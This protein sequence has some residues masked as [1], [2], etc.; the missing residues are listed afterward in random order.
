M[1]AILNI[2][3]LF[4][5]VFNQA[6]QSTWSRVLNQAETPAATPTPTL[7][8]APTETPQPAT[9]TGTPT[10]TP[11]VDSPT[12]TETPSVESPT[13]TETAFPDTATP[14]GTP[15]LPPT[16]TDVPLPSETPT[17]VP[18][19]TP[20]PDGTP[21]GTATLELGFTPAGRRLIL[22]WK[23]T[24][25][26]FRKDTVTLE[27][28]LPT[29]VIP[30]N[31][32]E[33]IFDPA[34]GILEV[35][36]KKPNGNVLLESGS[37]ESGATISASLFRDGGLAAN[38]VL[39]L[40]AVEK[41]AMDERGGEFTALNGRV[42]V[43]F[44]Q[45][46]LAGSATITVGR[47]DKRSA[48]DFSLSGNEFEIEAFADVND[49]ELHTFGDR[50]TI[51]IEYD[52]SSISGYE[53][54]LKLHWYN[55][56]KDKWFV[57]PSQ[58]DTEANILRGYTD[59][60]STFDYGVDSLQ[61]AH[62]PTLDTFQ[63]AEFTGAASYS[64]PIKVP[65]GPAGLQPSLALSYNSQVIDQ[66]SF[67]T[68]ASWVGMGWSLDTP[69]IERNNRG[70]D[71]E[72]VD[73]SF[74]LTLNGVGGLL[75]KGT[76]GYYHTR[77]ESF[78]RIE[79][80][81]TAN[82]WTAYDK[83]GTKYTFNHKSKFGKAEMTWRW[84]LTQI[85]DIHGN[86]I[87]Y[88]YATETKTITYYVEISEGVD[89][90]RHYTAT[91]AVYPNQITYAKNKY[92]I[93]F[94][95]D[96]NRG[97]YD[98]TWD[99][100]YDDT[101]HMR[102]RLTAIV[103]EHD[104]DGDGV[105]TQIRKYTFGYETDPAK[106]I[107]PQ[108][109][110]DGG[111]GGG[112]NLTLTSVKEY[113][114]AGPALPATTFEYD[115]MHL[116]RANNGYGGAVEFVY[117]TTPWHAEDAPTYSTVDQRF[118]DNY[119]YSGTRDFY[120]DPYWVV[121]NSNDTGLFEC[122][123]GHLNFAREIKN[124]RLKNNLTNDPT[125]LKPGSFYRL[126][127]K[128]SSLQVGGAWLKLGYYDGYNKTYDAQ[129]TLKIT[130]KDFEYTF[131]L[132]PDAKTLVPYLD[133]DGARMTQFTFEVLPTF[134][135]VT[136]K[137]IYSGAGSDPIIYE[138]AYANPAMNSPKSGGIGISADAATFNPFTQPYSEFRGHDSVTVTHPDGHIVT[139]EYHQA[140]RIQGQPSKVTVKTANANGKF[141]TQS[142]MYYS[143]ENIP[144][145]TDT[146]ALP[147]IKPYKDPTGGFMTATGL[148][149]Y[150]RYTTE[151]I[152]KMYT[153]TGAW[154]VWNA[155]RT[156]FDTYDAYG[157]LRLSSE[158]SGDSTS[159]PTN[160]Q[161]YRTTET[162]YFPNTNG[163]YLAGFP[164]SVKVSDDT[165]AILSRVLYVYDGQNA[166]SAPPQTGLLTSV[167]TLVKF[168]GGAGQYSFVDYGYDAYGNQDSVTTYDTLSTYNVTPT[169]GARTS[170]TVFDPNFHV[171]PIKMT[172]PI[173]HETLLEY[174]FTLGVPTREIPP[175]SSYRATSQDG[176]T[177]PNNNQQDTEAEYD[178]FGRVTK[179]I[180]PGDNADYPTLA[181]I[182]HDTNPFW[183]EIRQ[184]V[185]G[186][187]YYALRRYYDGMGRQ[188]KVQT[189]HIGPNG[190]FVQFN[191]V[192]YEY[193]YDAQNDDQYTT[194]QSVPYYETQAIDNTT[195]NQTYTAF[196]ALGRPLTVTAP[197]GTGASYAY[198]GLKT[199]VTDASG[200]A[201]ISSTDAWGNT[202][203]VDPADGP[204]VGYQYDTLSR[205]TQAV[206]G[207]EA[208]VSSCLGNST[209]CSSEVT[210]TTLT[211]DLAG[212]KLS[213]SDPDMGNWAYAYD[214]LGNLT[215]QKD[216]RGQRICLYY[217]DLNRLVGKHY[218]SDNNC[219]AQS[220]FTNH[221]LVYDV[222]FE[223]DSGDNGLGFRTGMS[224]A[225]GSTGWTYDERGRVE[226][227]TKSLEYANGSIVT[228]Q[229]F[230]T[231]WAYNSADL[232]ISMKYPDGED[233]RFDYT[234]QMMLDRVYRFNSS[235]IY[236]NDTTYDTA[237]RMTQRV[238][239]NDVL[240]QDYT[241]YAWDEKAAVDTA[242]VG[243]GGRLKSMTVGTLQ[244][245]DYL[246]DAVGNI[247][248][249]T[250]N[251]ASETNLYAYDSLNR[252]TQW[253][254]NGVNET[255]SY[256][257]NTGNLD[258]KADVDLNYNDASHAHAV[259]H[260][261]STQKYWYD[262]NGNQTK[263]VIG[264]D[265]FTL[266]YDAENRLVEV[267]KNSTTI[268]EFTFDGD[269]KRV[270]SVVDGETILFVGAHYEVKNPQS[271]GEVTKYYFAGASRIA[272]RKYTI[273]VS[274]S[275]EYMIGDHLG[276]TSMTTDATGVKISE[277]RY[278]AWGETRYTWTDAPA[279]PSPAYA[280]T[281]YQYTGQFSYEAEF[282]L[283]FYNARWYDSQLGRFAQAD[284]DVPGGVQ[285]L[286]RYV[287][288]N[289][290]PAMFIDLTGHAPRACVYGWCFESL[291]NGF[292]A[293]LTINSASISANL[294]SADG[295]RISSQFIG[296]G[297]T[298]LCGSVTFA[299]IFR[300]QNPSYT[301]NQV[302]SGLDNSGIGTN[303]TGGNDIVNMAKHFGWQAKN[304]RA[305][306]TALD[307]SGTSDQ[308][309]DALTGFISQGWVPIIGMLTNGGKLEPGNTRHWVGVVGIREVNGD[310]FISIY[311]PW[312]D[313]VKEYGWDFFYEL[314][315]QEYLGVDGRFYNN[316]GLVL[317][318]PPDPWSVTIPG[319]IVP[320]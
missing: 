222:Y 143:V 51:E 108:K 109:T 90:K 186:D 44:P 240:T 305:D 184:R 114:A 26:T 111:D 97:D 173:G 262:A 15:E 123:K 235:V 200:N 197:D 43:K 133:S 214:A 199:T 16:E 274:M 103:V 54:D 35:N 153:K 89:D 198:D 185:E 242:T 195:L 137:R 179:L 17:F 285:G 86:T 279:N 252:L 46:L 129:N 287:Y 135:R 40:P 84:S 9:P 234:L 295:K 132:R 180:R 201:T 47:P 69:Y 5:L 134:Y 257:P 170:T 269:G 61:I 296:D 28:T 13:A 142:L 162:L 165:G 244:N 79:Y 63:V 127:A 62:L 92:R 272:M 190:N 211:Y 308:R 24:G 87:T 203:H 136:E 25:L 255:Y 228:L 271:L 82:T 168:A 167:R 112:K 284:S 276:S 220:Q 146:S 130:E 288:A 4:V 148:A 208:V 236:V 32:N 37:L 56:E 237:G 3:M 11:I 60:F 307:L 204:S 192:K 290:S 320:Q 266:V 229:S 144:D 191:T 155:T 188:T 219:P 75:L 39:E 140:D 292:I 159:T 124:G 161:L 29:G 178:E 116:I 207:P 58:V 95:R 122:P 304:T 232:P 101:I 6:G 138:Y 239:G 104:A 156:T 21:D 169:G 128:A 183:V 166:F 42:R 245:L 150:T 194:A 126:Y 18:T 71:S 145:L 254:L 20:L 273:P 8:S 27:L 310:R 282:G 259:T 57:L 278:K 267:K 49:S 117:E 263:R 225:S 96:L 41:H 50:I 231:S 152:N 218:R 265:T 318:K 303:W 98:A 85:Q 289:N 52:E 163:V 113:G 182:Y 73:D 23:T 106:V 256:D 164:A 66:A 141:L 171:Y 209:Q 176:S 38:A 177:F 175:N 216:A 316:N 10:E 253:T 1:K 34:T 157:N 301:G 317:I 76:D 291:E 277:M 33:G 139:T 12:P 233:V 202:I 260:I 210:S 206:R 131:F 275:V 300:T 217:D 251:T 297:R 314:L 294:Y 261:G 125:L 243:Q 68:Q 268:A 100:I 121:A 77:E 48:P 94:V 7:E 172:N 154:N 238:L 264:P 221:E 226:S 107:F 196:D 91:L 53:G 147:Q 160:W 67:M 74:S 298:G 115:T 309:F 55:P 151:Q 223:Y 258:L 14:T 149:I 70:T 65:A 213:M 319:Q 181:V 212:R 224:D 293:I 158:Y 88:S 2:V 45:N 306:G 83:T 215:L 315:K 227:E 286:D 281:R 283:Y 280:M 187:Q 247:K 189:G 302:I 174:D 230:T 313:S 120:L 31:D 59:H 193:F 81:E 241:Y 19:E 105:F 205:L 311:N 99:G 102:S 110:W 246:Y 78:L 249:I 93:R 119:C 270:K 250:N 22:H 248:K 118:G 80:D 312:N 36:L 64:L 30:A 72:L 299:A